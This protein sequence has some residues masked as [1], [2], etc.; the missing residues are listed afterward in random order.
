[1]Q[2]TT[3]IVTRILMKINFSN[4]HTVAKLEQVVALELKYDGCSSV[5]ESSQLSNENKIA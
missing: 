3:K 1:M 2:T 4:G 5:E